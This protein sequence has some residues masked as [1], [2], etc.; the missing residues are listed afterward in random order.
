MAADDYTIWGYPDHVDRVGLEWYVGDMSAVA[1]QLRSMADKPG[2]LAASLLALNRLAWLLFHPE[3]GSA[4]SLR[5]I[6]AAFF[7][8]IPALFDIFFTRAESLLR[9]I[10]RPSADGLEQQLEREREIEV[11][12][13]VVEVS[14]VSRR[15]H[16]SVI[17]T[18]PVY[19]FLDWLIPA[20]VYGQYGFEPQGTLWRVI[21][22]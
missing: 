17:W 19:R 15:G 4:Y 5:R 1:P 21:P 11:K 12:G 6:A 7:A 14:H 16:R 10:P 9:G 22:F 18:A 8:E 3:E 2:S 13:S 20:V